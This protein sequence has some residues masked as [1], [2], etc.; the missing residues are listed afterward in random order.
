MAKIAVVG[1]DH[2]ALDR[3]FCSFSST[4]TEPIYTW[5]VSHGVDRS[6]TS[7]FP[8]KVRL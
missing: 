7:P 3:F 1:C 8:L 2:P 6:E 5:A 4:P